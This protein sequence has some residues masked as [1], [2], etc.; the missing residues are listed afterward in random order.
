MLK[1][2]ANESDACWWLGCYLCG[3]CPNHSTY[4]DLQ[5]HWTGVDNPV[6][7][8][9]LEGKMQI[10]HSSATNTKHPAVPSSSWFN[11]WHLLPLPQIV[12][13]YMVHLFNV[14]DICCP[15]F[16]LLLEN[17][18]LLLRCMKMKIAIEPGSSQAISSGILPHVKRQFN[19]MVLIQEHCQTALR[20]LGWGRQL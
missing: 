10:I 16:L 14:L 11:C 2:F 18:D 7:H 9:V 12:A 13:G 17:P 19:L 4:S 15:L 5:A 20:G 3:L 8:P 6:H 1:I